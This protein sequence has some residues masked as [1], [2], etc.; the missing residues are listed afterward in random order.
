MTKCS[1]AVVGTMVAT[2]KAE[3][4]AATKTTMFNV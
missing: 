1:C 2:T 3:G 4:G